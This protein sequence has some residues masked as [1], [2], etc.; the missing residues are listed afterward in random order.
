MAVRAMNGPHVEGSELALVPIAPFRRRLS[1]GP[2]QDVALQ[3]FGNVHHVHHVHLFR[4]RS[5]VPLTLRLASVR[6]ANSLVLRDLAIS[7]PRGGV[8]S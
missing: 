3:T 4:K 2:P 1:I 5:S 6:P 7:V 8:K